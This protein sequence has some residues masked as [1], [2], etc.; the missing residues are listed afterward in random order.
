MPFS[1]RWIL[2]IYM[3]VLIINLYS[4]RITYT[5]NFVFINYVYNLELSTSNQ[6]KDNLKY[7]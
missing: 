6:L 3:I 2:K 7:L 1:T 4:I 5:N